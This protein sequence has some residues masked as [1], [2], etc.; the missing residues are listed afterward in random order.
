MMIYMQVFLISMML[1]MLMYKHML[2]MLMMMELLVI[3]MSMIIYIMMVEVGMEFYLI[4]YLIFSVCESVLGLSLLVMI[5][6]FNG[7][8]LYYMFNFSKF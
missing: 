8:D 4:Y 7:N 3:N 2:I 1:L 5:V 6:R